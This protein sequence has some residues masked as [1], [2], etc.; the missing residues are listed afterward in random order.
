MSETASVSLG[1]R[2]STIVHPAASPNRSNGWLQSV[3]EALY[4]GVCSTDDLLDFG[5]DFG[6]P[7]GA[8]FLLNQLHDWND[9]GLLS[10]VFH[11]NG[12]IIAACYGDFMNTPYV[13]L[14]EAF[15]VSPY[16]F[17]QPSSEKIGVVVGTATSCDEVVLNQ[18][19]VMRLLDVRLLT[20]SWTGRQAVEWFAESHPKLTKESAHGLL[21]LLVR[22]GVIN[23]EQLGDGSRGAARRMWEFH[24]L[25]FHTRSTQGSGRPGPQGATFRFLGLAEPPPARKLCKW[26]IYTSLTR[27]EPGDLRLP[28]W[29]V[30]HQRRSAPDGLTSAGPVTMDDL[31]RFLTTLAILPDSL[32][33]GIYE[34]TRRLY[35]GAGA[36]YE[37][38]FYLLVAECED[39]P[40][41]LYYYDALTHSLHRV[42]EWELKLQSLKER[43]S[44]ATGHISSP[45]GIV[46]ISARFARLA[47][48]YE[49]IAYALCLKDVGVIFEHMY[50]MGA[51][52]RL[53]VCALGSVDAGLFSQITGNDPLVEP[54]VG[55]FMI[56]G[57]RPDS[58]E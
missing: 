33:P 45:A 5:L 51:A 11:S 36:C 47:W 38:E 49:G 35:P 19:I 2:L 30:L 53:E 43:A 55:Q 25:L 3:L 41:G 4:T 16:A 48:K 34:T 46:L 23:A 17:V 15:R 27:S 24:D 7:E 10:F 31:G 21:S 9:R 8:A 44:E 50:L 22:A 13:G 37:L 14:G 28:L 58:V 57:R 56:V 32:S 12:T 39:T 42:S 52:L 54:L 6:G 1:L 26:P 29:D 40:R 20:N 18:Q